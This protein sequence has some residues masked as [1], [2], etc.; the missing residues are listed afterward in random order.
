MIEYGFTLRTKYSLYLY[1]QN[2]NYPTKLPKLTSYFKPLIWK[3]WRK[4]KIIH[5]GLAA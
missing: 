1:T 5:R 2:K 3:E 4:K